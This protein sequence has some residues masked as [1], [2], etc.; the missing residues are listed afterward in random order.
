MVEWTD[1]HTFRSVSLEFNHLS[2]TLLYDPDAKLGFAVVVVNL[3]VVAT[4][5]IHKSVA[6]VVAGRL[7]ANL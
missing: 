4:P 3:A 1:S 2:E 5:L 7:K 6:P